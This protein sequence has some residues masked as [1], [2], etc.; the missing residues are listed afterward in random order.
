[1]II[2]PSQSMVLYW[3]VHAKGHLLDCAHLLARQLLHEYDG[4]LSTYFLINHIGTLELPIYSISC[5]PSRVHC[6]SLFRIVE[7]VAALIEISV[8][9]RAVRPSLGGA[10]DGLRVIVRHLGMVGMT[11]SGKVRTGWT[12]WEYSPG[13]W[14]SCT[15]RAEIIQSE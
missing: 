2:I 11:T 13:A 3:G 14:T 7:I 6:A 4:H 15:S 5:R 9:N 12:I 1:M 10:P 8:P